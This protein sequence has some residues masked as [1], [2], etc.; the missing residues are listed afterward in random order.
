MHVAG[1][2][3]LRNGGCVVYCW[4]ALLHTEWIQREETNVSEEWS[5]K[6][7]LSQGVTGVRSAVRLPTGGLLPDAFGEHMRSARKEL[8]MAFRSLF[9]A[10]IEGT[11]KASASARRKATKIK[12]E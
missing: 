9:D 6:N 1:T 10:A 3:N 8:L 2:R 12:V 11:D 7:W 4:H 5:L